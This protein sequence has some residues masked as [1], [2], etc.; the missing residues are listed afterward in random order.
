[1]LH[2]FPAIEIDEA[3]ALL[4][5]TQRLETLLVCV[6]LL[7]NA[8]HCEAITAELGGPIQ[9]RQAETEPW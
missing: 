2:A 6:C 3:P 8:L 7:M 5:V 4:S 1:M 9:E